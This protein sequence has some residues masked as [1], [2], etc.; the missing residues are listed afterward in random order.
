MAS[1]AMLSKD[2][3]YVANEI[4]RL[5]RLRGVCAGPQRRRTDCSEDTEKNTDSPHSASVSLNARNRVRGRLAGP[6]ARPSAFRRNCSGV[7][8]RRFYTLAAQ[9]AIRL[10]DVP[11]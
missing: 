6:S 8:V 2:W 11:E 4:Y 10:E 7:R 9:I 3:L 5:R 1:V